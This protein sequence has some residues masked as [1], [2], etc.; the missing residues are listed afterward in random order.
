M[1]RC[2]VIMSFFVVIASS[3]LVRTTCSQL[4]AGVVVCCHKHA[5]S[6]TA[7]VSQTATQQCHEL[8][9]PPVA[10]GLP[11]TVA[12]T[13][14]LQH[15]PSSA[16][17]GEATFPAGSAVTLHRTTAKRRSGADRLAAALVAPA[18]ANLSV[19]ASWTLAAPAM[20]PAGTFGAAWRAL[21]GDELVT[22]AD[23]QLE[24]MGRELPAA[25]AQAAGGGLGLQWLPGAAVRLRD[26]R[27]EEPQVCSLD[28]SDE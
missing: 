23:A 20:H 26:D 2:F 21:T 7:N 27:A 13:L 19:P 16:G 14:P 15:V 3:G 17:E 6:S 1:G 28:S 4:A 18:A 24:V 11:P 5:N 10:P 12:L 8:Y 9:D 22:S 25:A